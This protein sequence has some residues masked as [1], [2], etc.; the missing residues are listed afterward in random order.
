MPCDARSAQV[1]KGHG[2]EVENGVAGC[3][4]SCSALACSTRARC[5]HAWRDVIAS[6][7]HI[8]AVPVAPSPAPR[9]L[10]CPVKST[11]KR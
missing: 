5:S 10:I 6:Q 9:K 1:G 2:G 4:A 3:L 11:T 8:V 7:L